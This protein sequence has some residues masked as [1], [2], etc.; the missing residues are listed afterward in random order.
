LY[1]L[2][3]HTG[4]PMLT[5]AFYML[6]DWKTGL[7]R[8]ANAGHP[9][10]LHLR[11]SAGRVE[12]LRNASGKGQPAL[13]LIGDTNYQGTDVKLAPND[14]ILFHTDG[15]IDVQGTSGDYTPAMLAASVLQRLQLPAPRL[16]DE[17]LEEVRLFS[18]GQGFA[19]D[20]CV[21]GMELTP[22]TSALLPPK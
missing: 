18:G 3:K 6:A 13:G 2:L 7:A 8:Y 11:R 19:D 10:P 20:V 5:T 4:T 22:E 12:P 16:L 17:L 14:L 1:G 15:L 9:K 21:V